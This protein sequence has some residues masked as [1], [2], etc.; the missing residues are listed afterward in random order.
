MRTQFLGECTKLQQNM[1]CG[2]SREIKSK[3]LFLATKPDLVSGHTFKCLITLFGL[4][5]NQW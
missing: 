3:L 5:I 2:D 4:N 1:I